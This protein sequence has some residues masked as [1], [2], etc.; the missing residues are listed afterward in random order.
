M[1]QER[2]EDA[3]FRD[4]NR[5]SLP[6]ELRTRAYALGKRGYDKLFEGVT[7]AGA[8]EW[9]VVNALHILFDL[10]LHGDQS[11]L[12]ERFLELALDQRT[13]VRSAATKLALGMVRM[14]RALPY[15]AVPSATVE[16][17]LPI[18]KS[19]LS[20]GLEHDVSLLAQSLIS[21]WE[22]ATP[23]ER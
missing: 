15:A 7:D 8:T 2:D 20:K 3:F 9:Q 12:F 19:A 21:E 13:R 16:R 5:K 11:T 1:R 14:S 18:A 4:L 17:I 23:Q 6:D 10:R 22:T